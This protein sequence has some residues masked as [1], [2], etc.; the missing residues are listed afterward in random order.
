M[1]VSQSLHLVADPLL[2]GASSLPHFAQWCWWDSGPKEGMI[3]PCS[4]PF[5]AK[6]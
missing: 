3:S 5:A 6:G 2:S 4:G 1:P